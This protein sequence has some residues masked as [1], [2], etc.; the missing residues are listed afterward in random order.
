[1]MLSLILR[2]FWQLIV[3]VILSVELCL[4]QVMQGLARQQYYSMSTDSFIPTGDKL[5]YALLQAKQ[6]N[7]LL[8]QQ[9]SRLKRSIA[10]WNT[11]IPVKSIKRQANHS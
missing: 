9:V 11:R 10:F 8:R 6:Q 7:E 5:Y 4:L 1:M 3:A 2:S